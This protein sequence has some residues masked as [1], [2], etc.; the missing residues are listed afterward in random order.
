MH[1]PFLLPAHRAWGRLAVGVLLGA[2]ACAAPKTAPTPTAAA[3]ATPAAPALP[4]ADPRAATVAFYSLDNLYDPQDDPATSDQDF[5]P[6]GRLAWDDIRYRTKLRNLASVV[7]EIGGPGGPDV[8]GAVEMENRRVLDELVAQPALA[9]RGYQIAHFDSPDPRGSDC[10]LLYKAGRFE[11]TSQKAI[12]LTLPDT[13]MGTRDLL[14]VEGR[15]LGE[16]ITFL[17]AHWPSRRGG[18]KAVRRRYDVARQCRRVMDERVRANPQARVLLMGVFNDA[19]TDSSVTTYLGAGGQLVNAPKGELYN[20]FYDYQVA[21]KGTMYYRSRPDVFDHMV[22]T[23]GLLGQTGL[24]FKP[25]SATIFSPERLTSPQT[26]FP[27]EP[28]GSFLGRKYIGGYS[29][30][31]PVYLTLVK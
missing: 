26:K 25:G 13:T 18:R 9:G 30:H 3:A 24:R 4:P 22:L 27:G 20:A 31:F 12:R 10:A 8:L 17:V 14:L 23:P 16:P 7:A 15:L 29:D 21:G 1:F 28:L 2:A 11:P 6:T 19:P 5:T